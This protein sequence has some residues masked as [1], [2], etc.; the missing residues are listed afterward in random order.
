MKPV[1]TMK[2][3][4]ALEKVPLSERNLPPNTYELIKQTAA[5]YPDKVAIYFFLSGKDYATPMEITYKQLFARINQTANMLNDLGIGPKDVVTLILPNIPHNHFAIWGGEAAGIVSPINP[6]LDPDAIRDIMNASESKAIITLG[7]LPGTDIWEKVSSIIDQVPT[8]KTVIQVMGKSDPEKNIIGFDEVIDKYNADKLD[9]GRDIK[10]DDLCSMFHTGGTTGTPKLAQHIHS[11]EVYDAWA[12]SILANLTPNHVLLCGLPLF[13]V[14]GVIVTGLGPFVTGATIVLATP[15]GYRDPD[16]L[17]NFWKIV[18]H[19]KVNFFSGVPTVYSTLLL[20]P[21]GDSD[22]SSLEYA[23]CG[24]APMP[25]EVFREFEKRTNIKILEGYGLTEGTCASAV[26]PA[27]GER[28]VGS[29]GFRFP[30]QE[31]KIVDLDENGKYKRDCNPDEIGVVVIRGP[32]AFP[33]YKQEEHNRTAWVDDGTGEL[34]VNTGDLGRMDPEGYF[35]LTGRSKDLIIRGGHN[36]DP[37]MI[38][39][40]LHKHPDI[41]LAA[42]IGRPD[43]YAGEVPV[44]YVTLNPGSK[45]TADELLAYAKENITERA[46]VP[47]D[48]KII[49]DM[50]VT[51]IG[52]IFK[53]DLRRLITKDVFDQELAALKD[54]VAALTVVVEPDKIHGTL[55]HI[56]ASPAKGVE[57]AKVKEEIDKILGKFAVKY[58]VEIG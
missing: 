21:V 51:A 22:V 14:N 32:N 15:A 12:L 37:G 20:V 43:S 57:A 52:K 2:D 54:Q 49:D 17:P 33:G 4:E 31:M 36:I 38:E 46:A 45:A 8:L 29:I 3:I 42:A 27:G 25:V 9:S 26:N 56:K 1:S 39:E 23:I 10:P 11:N 30:Y 48:I 50:P 53:P 35:W 44:A 7:P 34:W 41:A 28:R 13:H 47:K 6:L 5:K 58:E 18:D 40:T 55:A 24:A 19:Y 16:V